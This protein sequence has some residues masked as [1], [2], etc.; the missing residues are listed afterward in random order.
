MHL[1]SAIGAAVAVTLAMTVTLVGAA[2]TVLATTSW[3][4]GF[5]VGDPSSESFWQAHML[6]QDQALGFTNAVSF[7]V[8][9]VPGTRIVATP[10]ISAIA[11]TINLAQQDG[12]TWVGFGDE[13]T[14]NCA[15]L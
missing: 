8:G 1:L 7:L 5:R 9:A 11:A 4:L 2:P 15:T 14:G 10:Q 13:T 6:N 12:L 3:G